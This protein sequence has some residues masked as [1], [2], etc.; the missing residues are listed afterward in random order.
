MPVE[1]VSFVRLEKV[2]EKNAKI[3]TRWASD[4]ELILLSRPNES[5][6]D[7]DRCREREW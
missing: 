3:F 4:L 2:S 1:K 6:E 5:R 7:D